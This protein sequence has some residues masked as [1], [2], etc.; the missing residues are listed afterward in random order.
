M[1]EETKKLILEMLD[2]QIENVSLTETPS[3]K[4][5]RCEYIKAKEDISKQV[6]KIE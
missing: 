4:N 5:L 1:K 6:V 3:L 2:E